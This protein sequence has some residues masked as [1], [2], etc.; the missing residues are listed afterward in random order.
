MPRPLILFGAFDRHNFGDLL[1]AHVA[2]ALWPGRTCLF[3]GL[4]AR[5]LRAC[6]GHAVQ[7][8]PALLAQ[9]APD[10]FDLLHVGGEILT[11]TA[12]EAAVMLQPPRQ[13]P[14]LLAYLQ[15]RPAERAAWVRRTLGLDE[16]VPYLLQR[17]R[18]PAL[19]RA[20]VLGAGGVALAQATPAVR[21]E[22]LAK[23][24]TLDA[25]AVRDGQTQ[26][27]LQA[28]GQASQL[29][30]DAAVLTHTLFG[31]RLQA[32]AARGEVAALR[33]RLGGTYLAV[34]CGA[35]FADDATLDALAQQLD[36]VTQAH[37]LGLALFRAGAAP[38]HDSLVLL[39]RLAQRLPPAR[40]QIMASL[41][42]W[43][44]AA[45][46]AASAGFVGSSLHAR[47]VALACGLPAVSLRSGQAGAQRDKTAAWVASWQP[48]A[49]ASV[50]EVATVGTA[51]RQALAVPATVR[52]ATARRLVRLCEQGCA[53]LHHTL[54]A[55]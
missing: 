17:Q 51:L 37:G 15:D 14:A 49:S 27:A 29:L 12:W 55:A 43:D 4:A 39:Q 31:Q 32:R 24:R 50:C 36:A 3:A 42:L 53:A 34:Q 28:M 18:W 44:I 47:I 21:A 13:A 7:P 11:T 23:L 20:A 6:G 40:V 19:R 5:D 9:A 10:S 26:A 2:A 16:E 38:W 48:D 35:E 25:V 30:P 41:Q 52:A 33:A 46:I 8:L 54:D 1:L 45:L 22:V